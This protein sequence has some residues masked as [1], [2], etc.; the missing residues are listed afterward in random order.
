MES[1][2][3]SA[4]MCLVLL[5]G[6]QEARYSGHGWHDLQGCDQDHHKEDIRFVPVSASLF[7]NNRILHGLLT[8]DCRKTQIRNE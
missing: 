6:Y 5:A 3:L 7:P 4:L 1:H 2:L 8:D